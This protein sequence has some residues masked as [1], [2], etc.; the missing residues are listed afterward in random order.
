M[1]QHRV[2]IDPRGDR[3]ARIAHQLHREFQAVVGQMA[4]IGID[5]ERAIG[6]SDAIQPQI[7]QRGQH[8]FAV[9]RISR[10]VGL[11]LCLAIERDQARLLADH[12][13]GE[14]QVAHPRA[15]LFR[16]VFGRHEPAQAPAGH[17]EILGKTVYHQR[18]GRHLQHAGRGH[19]IG[20]AVV[21]LVGDQADAAGPAYRGDAGQFVCGDHRAGG[22]GG[23][24]QDHRIG[25]GIDRGNGIGI[26]LEPRLGPG[27]HLHRLHEQR[28]GVVAIG[29]IAGPCK[30][31]ARSRPAHQR[32]RHDQRRRGAAGQDDSRRINRHAIAIQ[33]M[34]RDPRLQRVAFPIS[35]RIGVEHAMRLGDG[36]GRRPGRRL[37]EFHVD[38]IAA[39]CG[40]AMRQ[41]RYGHGVK[42]FQFG[43]HGGA[44]A[45]QAR[46]DKHDHNRCA[47]T[48]ERM[49]A[50]DRG[51]CL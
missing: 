15:R 19:A 47:A 30:G 7:G 34:R 9:A 42:G 43:N 16:Q 45:R 2:E 4:D 17:A 20:D 37:A 32:Q 12:R 31:D 44:L 28:A 38:D 14:K 35:H 46:I 49:I 39:L 13:R 21:D 3:H 10:H 36:R 48:Q 25:R 8:Q 41:C 23:A 18:V 29:H 5:V 33:V 24:G 1:A 6:R 26:Q 50:P 22:I 27:G 40:Q 11:K 51:E